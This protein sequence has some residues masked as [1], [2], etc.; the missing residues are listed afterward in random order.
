MRIKKAI[1]KNRLQ[2]KYKKI[3]NKKTNLGRRVVK[4]SMNKAPMNKTTIYK[5]TMNKGPMRKKPKK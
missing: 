3:Q 1:K 2:K 5:A 4:G